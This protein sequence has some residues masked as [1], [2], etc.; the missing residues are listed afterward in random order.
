M[1]INFY[2]DFE[3]NDKNNFVNFFNNNK[4][5]IDEKVNI[6]LD[7]GDDKNFSYISNNDI[8]EI[9]EKN[10]KEKI[11]KVINKFKKVDEIYNTNGIIV[12]I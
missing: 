2:C 9:C 3:V 8:D 5:I 6:K 4:N 7:T 12:K 11:E 10:T 1:D